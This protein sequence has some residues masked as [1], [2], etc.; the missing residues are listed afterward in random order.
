[1]TKLIKKFSERSVGLLLWFYTEGYRR[2]WR[3]TPQ[4]SIVFDLVSENLR[5]YWL[6]CE[7]VSIRLSM[8]HLQ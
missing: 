7:N 8:E 5:K 4:Y 1:M 3:D 6:Y 2:A